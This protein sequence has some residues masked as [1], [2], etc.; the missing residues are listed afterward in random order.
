MWFQDAQI[1]PVCIFQRSW[2]KVKFWML[3]RYRFSRTI[4][5]IGIYF[6]RILDRISR[7][8]EKSSISRGFIFGIGRK[9]A[10]SAKIYTFEVHVSGYQFDNQFRRWKIVLFLMNRQNQVKSDKFFPA[11]RF[12]L[13]ILYNSYKTHSFMEPSYNIIRT[14]YKNENMLT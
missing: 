8:S 13:T 3:L 5:F 14:F 10:K 1:E 9:F 6:W 7:R 4:L 12:F 2:Q 11:L